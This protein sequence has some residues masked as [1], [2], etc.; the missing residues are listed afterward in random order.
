M[1]GATCG[2]GTA[3]YSGAF[4]FTPILVGFMLLVLYSVFHIIF[5]F[6]EEDEEEEEESEEEEEESEEEDDDE[7]EDEDVI[8]EDYDEVG[9]ERQ[10]GDGEV[11]EC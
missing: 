11:R 3:Y 8:I 1:T 9:E 10:S 2:A 5:Y 6:Q 7:Y 4:E